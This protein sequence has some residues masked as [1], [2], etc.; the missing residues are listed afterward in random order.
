MPAAQPARGESEN[1]KLYRSGQG[2]LR[3]LPPLTHGKYA[4]STLEPIAEK[5]A[6]SVAEVR[7]AVE[8]VA[9]VDQIAQRADAWG[10]E[11]LLSGQNVLLTPVLVGKLAK[12]SPERLIASLHR[13]AEGLHPWARPVP[14]DTPPD[15]ARWDYH[16]CRFEEVSSWL[17]RNDLLRPAP[18]LGVDEKRV[19]YGQATATRVALSALLLA[20]RS[21]GDSDHSPMGRSFPPWEKRCLRSKP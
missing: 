20:L 5:H 15:L 12:R 1:R 11:L 16:L 10:K 18:S 7:T 2:Y 17:D 14:K 9:A 8:F 19:V 13:A 3:E 21:F 4:R 6:T